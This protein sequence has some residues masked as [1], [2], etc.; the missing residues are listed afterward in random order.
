M[1]KGTRDIEID[2]PLFGLGFIPYLVFSRSAHH[3]RD[4]LVA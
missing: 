1:N 2:I 4:R 3:C